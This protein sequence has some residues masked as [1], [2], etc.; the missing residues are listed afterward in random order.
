M[1]R[2]VKLEEKER[3]DNGSCETKGNSGRCG[4]L[5]KRLLRL[6]DCTNE[7]NARWTKSRLDSKKNFSKWI[8]CWK[9]ILGFFYVLGRK[10]KKNVKYFFFVSSSRLR[11]PVIIDPKKEERKKERKKNFFQTWAVGI[12]FFSLSLKNTSSYTF[13]VH[14]FYGRKNACLS[15]HLSVYFF[16]K[17]HPNIIYYLLILLI[18]RKNDELLDLVLFTTYFDSELDKFVWIV[19]VC[20]TFL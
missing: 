14:P 17:P 3:G 13:M 12:P 10:W 1:K 18:S 9:H 2:L 7:G 15:V 4:Q 20:V 11:Q 6:M 5:H 19:A 16:S 8:R